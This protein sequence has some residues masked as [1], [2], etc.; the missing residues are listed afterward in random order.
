M[1]EQLQGSVR[2]MLD[3]VSTAAI[4]MPRALTMHLTE[5]VSIATSSLWAHKLR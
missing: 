1:A 3:D 2:R 5:A 4:P